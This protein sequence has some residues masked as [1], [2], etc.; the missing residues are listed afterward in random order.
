M[1]VSFPTV[2][3]DALV[4][5]LESEG[6]LVTACGSDG[7]RALSLLSRQPID[8]MV[9]IGDVERMSATNLKREVG[10][11]WPAVVV[12][13]VPASEDG[14]G[15]EIP[16]DAEP[17]VLLAALRGSNPAPMAVEG[18]AEELVK[19]LASLTP[20]ERA[21][22]RHLGLGYTPSDIAAELGLSHNTIRSHLANVH[23]KLD[24][25]RRVELVRLAA[26]AG[27]VDEQRSTANDDR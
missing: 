2:F 13:R 27:L 8:A 5:C 16:F 19:R 25:H 18:D 23:R 17:E 15:H 14:N 1:V 12:V 3:R 22:V 20:R 4:A 21:V 7:L 10:R 26:L 9:L 24:V 11:R 6:C